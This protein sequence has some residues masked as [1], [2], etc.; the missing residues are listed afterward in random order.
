MMIP[1]LLEADA[2]Q[3]T[4]T[5]L[6]V[7]AQLNRSLVL[8]KKALGDT[9]ENKENTEIANQDENDEKYYLRSIVVCFMM[10]VQ[11]VEKATA[12]S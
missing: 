12:G 8:R 6:Y 10:C 7:T 1:P 2:D 3:W 4:Y 5:K 11:V 9:T